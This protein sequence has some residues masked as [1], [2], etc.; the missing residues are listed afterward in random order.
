MSTSVQIHLF[1]Q[2]V[3]LLLLHN[4]GIIAE[5]LQSLFTRQKA[6]QIFVELFLSPPNTS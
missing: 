6:P 2:S 4:F 3:Q 1:R 5:I